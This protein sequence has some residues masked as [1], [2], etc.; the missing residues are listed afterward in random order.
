MNLL[1]CAVCRPI[2]SASF[3]YLPLDLVRWLWITNQ[4]AHVKLSRW[5]GTFLGKPDEDYKEPT[6]LCLAM[7]YFFNGANSKCL[8][9]DSFL[10]KLALRLSLKEIYREREGNSVIQELNTSLG[11]IRHSHN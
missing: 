3:V 8:R 6:K 10:A 2:H 5:I 7:L 1:V 9:A 11:I 4:L